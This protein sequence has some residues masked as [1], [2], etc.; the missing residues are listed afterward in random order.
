MFCEFS[1]PEHDC[2]PKSCSGHKKVTLKRRE[3]YSSEWARLDPAVDTLVSDFVSN[4]ENDDESVQ[5]LYL[6]DWSLPLFAPDLASKVIIPKYFRH[7][8]LKRTSDGNSSRC[9][10]GVAVYLHIQF[11]SLSD[12][13]YRHSWPSLFVASR[14]VI[15]DLH[16]D[17]FASHFWMFL[18]KGRKRWTFFHR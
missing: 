1:S 5:G 7:D 15:S 6:F 8:F 16:V 4:I 2:I 17:A 9:V 18:F 13:L 11:L 10:P 14:G 3:K 12:A